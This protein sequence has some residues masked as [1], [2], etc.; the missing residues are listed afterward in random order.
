MCSLSD[1]DHVFGPGHDICGRS[2]RE[3]ERTTL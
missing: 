2:K 1:S 3:R